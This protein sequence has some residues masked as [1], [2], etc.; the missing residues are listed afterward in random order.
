M[1]LRS[2]FS[3]FDFLNR[4]LFLFDGECAL[5]KTS[6]DM[7]ICCNCICVAHFVYDDTRTRIRCDVHS[8]YRIKIVAL[9]S[10]RCGFLSRSVRGWARV[11]IASDVLIVR[12]QLL[13]RDNGFAMFQRK[14][15]FPKNVPAFVV[16]FCDALDGLCCGQIG[17]G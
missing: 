9:G 14:R 16:R 7:L 3:K 2:A 15:Q 8:T 12:T 4:V 6:N 11:C 10:C 13:R 5:F 1:I 17:A